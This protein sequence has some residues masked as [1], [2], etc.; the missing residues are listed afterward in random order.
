MTMSAASLAAEIVMGQHDA[1]LAQIRDALR[2]RQAALDAA[3]LYTFNVGD[4]V[5]F[6]DRISP[7]YL[8][9]RQGTITAIGAEKVTLDIGIRVGKYGP[10]VTAPVS[11]VEAV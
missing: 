5:R 6:N 4:R 2:A 11:V 7:R 3:K 10:R 1:H 8:I 9:G